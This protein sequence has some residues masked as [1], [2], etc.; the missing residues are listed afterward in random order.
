MKQ[1][2]RTLT[3]YL[4]STAG[5]AIGF[6][7]V[8]SPFAYYQKVVKASDIPYEVSSKLTLSKKVNLVTAALKVPVEEKVVV[9]DKTIHDSLEV[10]KSPALDSIKE[11]AVPTLPLIP[12]I[13]DSNKEL[14]KEEDCPKDADKFAKRLR[15]GKKVR[16]VATAYCLNGRTASGVTSKYGIIAA[17]PIYLPIGSIVRLQVGEYSG[18][19]S[20][21][22]TGAK[23]KGKKIDV[24]LTS[25]KEAMKFGRRDITLEVLRYGWNPQSC[26]EM[27]MGEAKI[28]NTSAK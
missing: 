17:D 22:D 7:A 28:L 15:N 10:K 5:F 26:S 6:L 9:S 14:T 18:L 23:I 11:K 13:A 1:Q 3:Y 8:F 20:V 12:N 24:Y 16:M 2:T 25:G 21:L 27:A 19:Y 4:A